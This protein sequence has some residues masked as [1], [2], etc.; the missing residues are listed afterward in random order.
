[1]TDVLIRCFLPAQSPQRRLREYL[2]GPCH[3]RWKMQADAHV[4]MVVGD[5]ED[6]AD[7]A[8]FHMDVKRWAEQHCATDIYIVADDDCL[9]LGADF[10]ET[11]VTTLRKHP[12]YGLLTATSVV[13][14][15]QYHND[16]CTGVVEA[17]AVG[18]VAF[19]RKGILTE[20]A[21]CEPDH[22][23]D[24]ICAEMKRKGYKTGIMPSVQMNHIG[25]GFSLSSTG[26]WRA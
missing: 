1:M 11:G 15:H 3:E 22:T 13:E 7:P 4:E 14:H 19:V 26:L 25:Y 2:M 21:S 23:D 20:F 6:G 17:H 12:E 8:T 10:V 5:V 9:I 18:G 16:Y 24:T